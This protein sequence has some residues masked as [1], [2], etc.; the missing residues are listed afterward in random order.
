M[1]AVHFRKNK[2]FRGYCSSGPGGTF[3]G[4]LKCSAL[5]KDTA[6]GKS[7]APC[8]GRMHHECRALRKGYT[9][10]ELIIVMAI[11]VF[12]LSVG[13]GGMIN[14]QRQLTFLT[15]YERVLQT[16]RDARSLALAGKAMPDY[17]DYD[18]DGLKDT[19]LVTP[20]NYGVHFDKDNKEIVMFADIHKT[21][22]DS[23]QTE[24]KYQ[25]QGG[26]KPYE[27]KNSKDVILSVYK[28]DGNFILVLAGMDL[29][30]GPADIFFSPIFADTTFDPQLS[31]G[32]SFFIFG[33]SE[34]TAA[35]RHKCSKIHPVAGVPENASDTECAISP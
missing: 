26:Q 28:L 18:Q 7:Y 32:K 33:V 9:L 15:A 34:R 8:K 10:I 12:L 19:D 16:V 21:A 1:Q 24:G 3:N 2:I 23:G 13:L 14:S 20:A 27:Y 17:T 4:S 31:S 5:Y 30:S 29:V 11:V 25:V 22:L 6:L 35:G